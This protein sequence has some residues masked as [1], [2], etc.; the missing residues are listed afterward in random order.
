MQWFFEN[1]IES[2]L[3]QEKKL[4]SN[5]DGPDKASDDKSRSK[6]SFLSTSKHGGQP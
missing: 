6:R 4:Q 1:S 2:F 3:K 5:D